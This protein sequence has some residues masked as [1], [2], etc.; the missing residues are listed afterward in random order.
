MARQPVRPWLW[1]ALAGAVALAIWRRGDIMAT[2]MMIKKAAHPSN[3]GAPRTN[4]IDLVVL[5][6]TEGTLG[7]AVSWFAMDHAPYNMGPSSAH[8]VI[9][10]NGQIVQ[11]VDDSV[12]AWHGSDPT[13]NGR[14]IGIELEGAA[15]DPD[16]FTP[17]MMDSLIS[18]AKGLVQK[19][20]IPVRRGTPGFIAHSDIPAAAKKGKVDVGIYFDWNL[21]FN[22]IQTRSN[23]L[24]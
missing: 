13:V 10:K 4:K 11:M 19:Y 6:T 21:L 24:V 12:V 16:N 3:V 8:Y 23:N 14:S 22:E 9:G 15:S 18:L 5:H 20:G 17:L 2:L 7:S 1:F